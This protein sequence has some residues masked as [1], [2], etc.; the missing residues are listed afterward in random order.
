MLSQKAEPVT[1]KDAFNILLRVSPALEKLGK[2]LEVRDGIEV[3]RG[4]LGAKAAVE[5]GADAAVAR[6]AQK[7]TD[8]VNPHGSGNVS[9][10]IVRVLREVPLKDLRKKQFHDLQPARNLE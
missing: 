2:L 9:A 7:L 6:C 10:K 8:V 3:A 5:V 4:L 1:R